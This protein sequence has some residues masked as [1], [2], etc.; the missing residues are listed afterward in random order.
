MELST[1]IEEIWR[2]LQRATVDKRS[3]FRTPVLGTQHQEEVALRTLVLRKI[4]PENRHCT[5]YTDYRTPKIRQLLFNPKASLLF[6]HP[7]KQLQI[8]LNGKISIHHKNE[9]CQAVWHNLPL[10]SRRD[11]CTIKAPSTLLGKDE[12]IYPWDTEYT[13]EN[14]A[15]GFQNFTILLFETHKIDVLQLHHSGHQRELH[16]WKDNQW[17]T[18]SIV[19]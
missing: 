16:Q 7:K 2:L 13:F 10:Y 5:F 3:P 14:T 11:Y 12:K 17:I 8:R 19:P 15:K 4:H 18:T 9:L 6:Y 1:T